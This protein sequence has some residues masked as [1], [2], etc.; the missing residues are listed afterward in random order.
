MILSGARGTVLL[1]KQAWKSNQS[2]VKRKKIFSLYR[3]RKMDI[4]MMFLGL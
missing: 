3:E 4:K 1:E 2:L